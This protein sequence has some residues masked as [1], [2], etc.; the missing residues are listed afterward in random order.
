[1]E[2]GS[3]QTAWAMLHRLRSVLVRPGRELLTGRVE[4]DET[5][6]GGEEP[7]LRGGRQKG[8]KSLVAEAVEVREPKGFG[9]CSTGA[10]RSV[11][12][13]AATAM[14]STASPN[15]VTAA[16]PESP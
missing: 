8:K 15:A 6:I 16:T 7:G 9:R 13:R 3:Y 12:A 4:V 1:M 14:A 11:A 10:R 2:I 5:F